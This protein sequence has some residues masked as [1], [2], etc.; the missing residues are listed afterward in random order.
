L[1][2]ELSPG[3]NDGVIIARSDKDEKVAEL[4]TKNSVLLTVINHTKHS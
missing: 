1:I 2:K 4:G 3:D